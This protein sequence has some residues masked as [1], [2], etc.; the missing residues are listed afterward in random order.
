[1]C[2]MLDPSTSISSRLTCTEAI[3]TKNDRENG[4]RGYKEQIEEPYLVEKF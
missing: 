4:K 3:K 2:E 1:M